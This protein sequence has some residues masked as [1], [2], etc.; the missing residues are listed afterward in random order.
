MTRASDEVL[1]RNAASDYVTYDTL[2]DKALHAAKNIYDPYLRA[3]SF[4]RRDT[5]HGVRVPS[6]TRS[7]RMSARTRAI[8]L[9]D[10]VPP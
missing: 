9:A 3:I 2:C 6:A 5:R 4:R 10:F 1:I 7:A 8:I